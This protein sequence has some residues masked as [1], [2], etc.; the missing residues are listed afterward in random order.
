[1]LGD[2]EAFATLGPIDAQARNWETAIIGGE[3]EWAINDDLTLT[4][5]P[6]YLELDWRQGYWLT[7]KDGDFGEKIDQQTHELRLASDGDGPVNWLAGFYAYRIDTSGQLFIQFG[8]D[9]LFP[10]SP[11]GLWL[12]ASDVRAHTLEGT[13]LFGEASLD[14]SARARLVVGGRVS[15]DER[16]GNG[17]QPDIIVE[18]AVETDP[19]ALFTGLPP[20][21]WSNEASW[22]HVDW[23]LGVEFDASSESL[24]YANVQTGYQPGTFDVFPDTVTP[25]SELTAFTTGARNRFFDNQLVFNVEGFFYDYEN[26]LTQAFDAATGTNRLTSADVE[27]YGV[28]LDTRLSPTRWANTSIDFSIG[29]LHARYKDFLLDEL[30]I[31]NDNQLQNAPDWTV[32]LR[33]VHAW[34]LRSGAEI[35]AD[36]QSRYESGFWGDFLHSPGIYQA[37]YTKTNLVLS[38][39]S[40]DDRWSVGAWVNNLEDQDVQA[41]AATG[42]P[43]TDPGPGAP[44]L[45]PPR[46]YG[47]RLAINWGQ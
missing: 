44:F 28:Q 4:Y 21:T 43:I 39:H 22:D 45:E 46:T 31:Y 3:L 35:R 15:S 40:R 1:M 2:L 29:Y 26:L 13:A 18:P 27:I 23:K 10:T 36:L 14:L 6:A 20:D 11:G 37:S 33:L 7:H 19:I 24:L 16:T 17:F 38:Y 30:D 9:E 34:P 41:A 12:N 42:N 8:P 25:Q 47:L 32:N 5:L